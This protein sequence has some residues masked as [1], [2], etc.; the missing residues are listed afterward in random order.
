MI[1]RIQTVFLLLSLLSM[2]LL[3]FFP[4]ANL[5]QKDSVIVEFSIKGAELTKDNEKLDYN[6]LPLTIIVVLSC[7]ITFITI[8]LFKKRMIQIRLSFLN[9]ILQLGTAGM[10]YYFVYS[11]NKSF[12]ESFSVNVMLVLPLVAAI[13]SF[14]AIRAIAKDEALVRSIDRIR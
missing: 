1:Q 8:L 9:I 6:V 4:Y 2:G 5:E 11:A 13:F 12:G 3:F 10:M 14:L 7:C